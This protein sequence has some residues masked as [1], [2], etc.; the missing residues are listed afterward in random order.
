MPCANCGVI[1]SIRVANVQGQGSGLGAVAGGVAGG[2]LG[3]Q[4]GRGNGRT[5]ATIAGAAGGAYAG[6]AIEKN[7]KKHTVYRVT[8][9]MEDGRLRTL[10]Q[11]QAPAFAV[12]DRVRVANGRITER[13]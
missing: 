10:S 5:V 2:L 9:R 11:R 13:A 4:I 1:E 12:G 3:N 8:L 6:N 7:M